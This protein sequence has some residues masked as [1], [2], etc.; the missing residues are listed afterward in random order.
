V[1]VLRWLRHGFAMWGDALRGPC[2]Q[3]AVYL[4]E[5]ELARADLEKGVDELARSWEL[6]AQSDRGG[7]L[8]IAAADKLKTELAECRGYLAD[9]RSEVARLT[10]LVAGEPDDSGPGVD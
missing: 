7:A 6:R 3:C 8:A 2:P 1:N 9:S 4:H 5:L 10:D